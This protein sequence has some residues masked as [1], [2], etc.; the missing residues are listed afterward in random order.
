MVSKNI[1]DK[2]AQ[3]D[4]A[5]LQMHPAIYIDDQG[6]R[7]EDY[8]YLTFTSHFDC[9]DR[10]KSSYN[11]TP[12]LAGGETLFSVYSYSLDQ[13]LLEQTPLEN[14]LLFKMGATTDGLVA[15][16]KSIVGMFRAGSPS[17][18]MLTK[19]ADY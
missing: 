9:W 2:L 19:V 7:H 4:I 13:L 14:R 1:H 6:L 16:H 17:G 5:G 3:H 11:S 10:K 12:L 18:A 15:C 8:W